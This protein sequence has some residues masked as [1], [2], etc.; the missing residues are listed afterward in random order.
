MSNKIYSNY[1]K[2]LSWIRANSLP[3]KGIVVSNQSK[4]SYPEV[5][6]YLIPTLMQAGEHNLAFDYADFL[7]RV[8]QKNGSFLGIDKKEYIFDSGQA[9]RGLLAASHRWSK[10]KIYAHKTAEYLVRSM[11]RNGR[12]PPMYNRSISDRVCV[13][14]L[15]PLFESAQMFKKEKIKLAAQKSLKYYKNQAGILEFNLLS[16]FYA[17]IIDGFIEMGEKKFVGHAV[18]KIFLTQK[19]NGAIPAYRNSW[20]SCSAGTAQFAVIGYKMGFIE[21]ANSA[22]DWLIS[23]QNKSGGFFGS[24]GLGA[25]YFPNEEI[26]WAANFFLDAIS[27]RNQNMFLDKVDKKGKALSRNTWTE[28]VGSSTPKKIAA[29]IK[30]GHCPSWILPIL[31]NT[32]PREK[33]LELGS[34]TGQLSAILAVNSRISF[35]IDF[36]KK[37]L[38]FSKK[39]FSILGLKG[40]FILADVRKRL[41]MKNEVV[42][43]VFSSGLLEHFHDSQ[44]I[45][46]LKEMKRVAKKGVISLV[47]NAHSIFYTIGKS[48]MEKEGSWPYGQEFPQKS[49]INFYRKVGLKNIREFSIDTYH[50]LNF[51]KPQEKKMIESIYQSI[52]PDTLN[53]LNQ[54][55]LLFTIGNK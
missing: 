6:G 12:F 14:V 17:Y 16:H 47:P 48:R 19:R 33:I 31:E 53:K 26:S 24:Y 42:D 35:L 36:S 28:I 50:A 34:G 44:I 27:R 54:G 11:K 43:W 1:N 45:K 2:A 13:Y 8:Q 40:N 41:P 38:D 5:T 32:K 23:V 52:S 22:I 29:E 7:C 18:E 46:M 3:G 21:E 4:L 20:W 9:L 30:S 25:K 10:Y 49:L 15:P 39:T 55:Y 51:L 37:N